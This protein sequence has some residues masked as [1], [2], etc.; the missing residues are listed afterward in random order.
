MT[1]IKIFEHVAGALDKLKSVFSLFSALRAQQTEAEN[2]LWTYLRAHR[3]NGLK[4]RR[5]VVLGKYIVDFLCLS[6]KIIVEVDG[7]QHADQENYDTRRTAYLESKGYRVLR[8]WNNEV[9]AQSEQ[10]LDVIWRA[11]GAPSP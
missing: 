9:L 7:G 1:A 5:Q 2:L 10:V 3:L 8:F 11:C 6:E 4:F